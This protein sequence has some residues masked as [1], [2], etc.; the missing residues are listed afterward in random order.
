MV[1][2]RATNGPV[3]CIGTGY[4]ASTAQA[5]LL[6]INPADGSVMR[7]FALGSPT[8]GNKIGKG[9][10]FDSDFDGYEDKLYFGD[11]SGKIHR[12]DLTTNPWT[13]STLYSGSQPIQSGLT[14]TTDELGRAMLFF[15]TGQFITA[16]DPTST[17]QQA[18]YGIIDDNSGTTYH[19]SDLIN[20][21]STFTAVP[22]GAH[23]WYINLSETGERIIRTPA[24]IAGTLYVPSFAP[25]TT[26]CAGGG[27]SWLYSVDFR[28]GSAPDRNNVENNSVDGRSQSM[29]DGIL[30]D[31]TVD[32]VNEKLILQS[33]NAV[34]LTEDI[35]AD[36]NKLLVRSWRQRLN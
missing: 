7:T 6:V 16:S 2:D 11:L 3:L 13:V 1:Q 21:T 5:N 34:L 8:A 19:Q 24:L 29:G 15:G 10:S 18:L 33:S 26:A 17:S 22:A 14:L 4:D 36:L 27:Q 30:A 12:V 35:S 31:P 20:Q 9:V 28:D 25:T 32:L 23:G